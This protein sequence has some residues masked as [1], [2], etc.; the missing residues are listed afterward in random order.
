MSDYNE[1][2]FRYDL[3]A[4]GFCLKENDFKQANIFA[5]RIMSNASLFDKKDFGIIGH[6]F[7][8]IANDGIIAQ[9]GKNE[10]L[11]LEYSEK[12]QKVMGIIVKMLDTDSIHLK[13]IWSHFSAHQDSTNKLFMSE[14]EL[15]AYQK[16]DKGFSNIAIQ[17]IMKI[18]EENV[19]LLGYRSNDLYRGILNEIGRM[20]KVYGLYDYD[21]HFVS[22]LRMMQK[23]DEY[24]KQTS[25]P[26][27]F[28]DRS[29]KEIILL[30]QEIISVYNL[31]DSDNKQEEKI[32]NLLWILIKIW[33]LFFIKFMEPGQ[34]YYSMKDEQIP[35]DPEKS[36]L[37]DEVTK[38]IEKE[39]GV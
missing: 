28:L 8:E 20:S 6:I 38:Y 10:K 1:I 5:N 11:L 13:K 16:P 27:D 29:K 24:V 25:T 18:L 3:D 12:S 17:K 14:Y 26:N 36:K 23:I 31:I 30:T 21:E 35:D 37:V 32:D 33:R 15:Q 9:Q 34:V 7:K 19:A 4:F 2:N 39:I 22:L